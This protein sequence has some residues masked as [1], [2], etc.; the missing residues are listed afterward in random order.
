[1]HPWAG[2]QDALKLVTPGQGPRLRCLLKLALPFFVLKVQV[3]YP[4]GNLVGTMLCMSLDVLATAWVNSGGG[5][6]SIA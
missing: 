2:L 4:K 5:E 6:N 1:M 3:L